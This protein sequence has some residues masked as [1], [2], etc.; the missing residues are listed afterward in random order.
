MIYKSGVRVMALIATLSSLAQPVVAAPVAGEGTL[1]F[2]G[3]LVAQTC[4]IAVNNSTSVAPLVQLPRVSRKGM[5]VEGET[6]GGTR[7]TF[8]FSGCSSSLVTKARVY[9]QGGSNVSENG[10]LENKL[11][12]HA[13]TG[14]ALQLY[15]ASMNPIR[16]GDP[17]QLNQTAMPLAGLM[18][19][20][21]RYI[22]DSDAIGSGPFQ[23]SVTYSISYE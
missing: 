2:G 11:T 9:F 12:S 6:K 10:T 18:E 22:A 14:V 19:Y 3:R 1:N 21:V 15:D 20:F 16:V 7:F 8:K 23:T 13:A 5:S 4:T 17:S